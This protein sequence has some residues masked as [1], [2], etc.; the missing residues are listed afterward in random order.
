MQLEGKESWRC[1][2]I[3]WESK[4]INNNRLD[5]KAILSDVG[6]D[7]ILA[8]LEILKNFSILWSLDIANMVHQLMTQHRTRTELMKTG[9]ILRYNDNTRQSCEGLILFCNSKFLARTSVEK[10]W[11]GWHRVW[12]ITWSTTSTCYGWRIIYCGLCHDSTLI[13]SWWMHCFWA[14]E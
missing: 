14:A 6:V 10:K 1:I 11:R 3:A 4:G 2:S 13:L 12:L 5:I 8:E 9:I 7:L